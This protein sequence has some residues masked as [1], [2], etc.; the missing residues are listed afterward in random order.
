MFGREIV[1]ARGLTTLVLLLWLSILRLK[2]ATCLSLR[3]PRG[4]HPFPR[5]P[6]LYHAHNGHMMYDERKC[7]ALKFLRRSIHVPACAYAPRTLPILVPPPSPCTHRDVLQ[8]AYHAK[9]NPQALFTPSSFMLPYP[10]PRRPP[11]C[12]LAPASNP[13]TPLSPPYPTP[14]PHSFPHTNRSPQ[15]H[16][17]V[18]HTT[19]GCLNPPKTLDPLGPLDPPTP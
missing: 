5:L 16:V 19:R 9:R 2:P 18:A 17:H 6:T 13:T 12:P 4:A 10:K 3:H 7:L 1:H 11:P 15:N 14:H 8:Q